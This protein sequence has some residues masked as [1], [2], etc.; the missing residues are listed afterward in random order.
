MIQEYISSEW[1]K[2]IYDKLME[3]RSQREKTLEK[4]SNTFGDPLELSSFY[5]E[6]NC[7]HVNPADEFEDDPISSVRSPITLT[8]N[9]FFNGNFVQGGDGRSHL[10]VLSDAGMGKTSLLVMTKLGY[11]TKPWPKPLSCE[12]LKLGPSTLDEIDKIKKKR[13]TILLL[14]ALDEDPEAWGRYKER[15]IELMDQTKMFHR[16]II[17]CRTQFFPKDEIDPFKRVGQLKIGEYVSPMIF[18]SLFDD[19]QVDQYIQKRFRN[20]TSKIF[21]MKRNKSLA[22]IENMGSLRFRP[23]LLAYI[24]DFLESQINDWD[25]YNIYLVLVNTWISRE[26]SKLREMKK[27]VKSHDI[28]EACIHL[29]FYMS[30]KG[31]R[32]A[33]DMELQSIVS[34]YPFFSN[35]ANVG[36]GGRSLLN[37]NAEGEYRFSHYTVQE[38]L[39]SFG[40]LHSLY[41][42]RYLPVKYS[43]KT[44]QFLE[45]GGKDRKKYESIFQNVNYEGSNLNNIGIKGRSLN[46]ALMNRV[47]IS[48]GKFEDVSM[49]ALQMVLGTISNTS[50]KNVN[51]AGA[52]IRQATLKGSTFIATNFAGAIINFAKF[53]DCTFE[54]VSFASSKAT[55]AVFENCEFLICNFDGAEFSQSIFI[56]S[57][58]NIKA[59]PTAN[60]EN[61]RF[62][63]RNGKFRDV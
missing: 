27:N 61:V 15:V 36:I 5:V 32:H 59:F 23:L 39:I 20:D 62:L 12:L 40:I 24:D 60:V 54:N 17:S 16:T 29:A 38:F 45:Q 22:I 4:I 8:L 63:D 52:D 35:L 37:R 56:N 11:I 51:L 58:C 1:M 30:K 44:Q 43:D 14:D 10:F 31:K 49:R 26:A 53:E 50:F 57:D 2:F 55:G 18:I 6:P 47:H 7:Q 42:D 41:Q 13:K 33:T 19:L 9:N 48:G 28:L 21:Q 34:R 25:E 46:D 3:I